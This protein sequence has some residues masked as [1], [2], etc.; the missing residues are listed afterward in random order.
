MPLSR[1]AVLK[2][3]RLQPLIAFALS[4]GWQV[5]LSPKGNIKIKRK[6]YAT[7]YNAAYLLETAKFTVQER[8]QNPTAFRKRGKK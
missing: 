4:E 3:K 6:G 1:L 2:N 5:C 8:I 7:I